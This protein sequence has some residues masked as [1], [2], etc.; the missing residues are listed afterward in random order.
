MTNEQFQINWIC[1]QI[2]KACGDKCAEEILHIGCSLESSVEE[3]YANC[4]DDTSLGDIVQS[5]FGQ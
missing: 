3:Y 5:Y 2:R 4:D 1:E